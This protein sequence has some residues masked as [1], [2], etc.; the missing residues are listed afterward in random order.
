MFRLDSGL[1]FVYVN[2]AVTRWTGF[3]PAAFH[4]KTGLEAG[5]REA[6]WQP[7]AAKCREA[8]A[9]GRITHLEFNDDMPQG[10]LRFTV[11]LVPEFGK[12]GQVATLL[13][14][15]TVHDAKRYAQALRESEE[16]LALA[17]DAAGLGVFDHDM[18]NHKVYWDERAAALWGIAPGLPM[19]HEVIQAHVHPDY[20]K[21]NEAAIQRALDPAGSGRLF[22]E[23]PVVDETGEYVRWLSSNGRVLFEGG[24]AVR[25][26]G[27]LQDITEHK[28]A[29]ERALS[30][31]DELLLLAERAGNVGSFEW[32]VQTGA[33]RLSPGLQAIYGLDRFDGRYETWL[34][35][36][37]PDD[38]G[39]VQSKVANLF[40]QRGTSC[41][42]EYRVVRPDGQTRW[43]ETHC[44]V[45][46]D[47][48][49]SPLHM[50]AQNA[51][52]T[53]HKDA[54]RLLLEAND[55]LRRMSLNQT[56]LIEEE[57]SRIARNLHDGLGQLLYL[58][59]IKLSAV[60]KL[61]SGESQR[62]A[63]EDVRGIMAQAMRDAR[64][65]EF[66]LSPPQ[67]RQFGLLP[68]LAW[69]AEDM[70]RHFALHVT[71]ADDRRDKPLD[72]FMSAIL[73]RATRELLINVAKHA[74][75]DNA[76]VDVRRTDACIEIVVR[77]SGVGLG[78]H[79]I[80]ASVRGLGLRGLHEALVSGGGV[81]SILSP[82]DGGTMATLT[83]PLI[84][85]P[86]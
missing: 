29:Q 20:R 9:A 37:H 53:A 39:Q 35:L 73:Y 4:G 67:L 27:V 81:F 28:L 71:V 15:V 60:E 32:R 41:M 75:V 58:V 10:L 11:R 6:V 83:A 65:I 31:K 19:T 52:I 77:D 46:Y 30:E 21:P 2:A 49:G 56:R 48:A 3:T 5:L 86:T 13:G 55:S 54:E 69:L 8:Y 76:R 50:I 18:I 61:A 70:E 51:D 68:A 23:Y 22:R 16:K 45:S 42:N 40:A 38:A 17:K 26:I 14:I 82:A 36:I 74:Q 25:R 57:R 43:I 47:E 7:I 12:E 85:D 24:R 59:G 66:E 63:I 1:R 78:G 79:D 62:A 84:P 80:M 34:C 72:P 64:S 44:C 33:M